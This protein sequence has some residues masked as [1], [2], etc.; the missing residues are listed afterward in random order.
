MRLSACLFALV[1]PFTA[2]PAMADD[3]VVTSVLDTVVLPGVAE[4]AS[5]T[6]QL[7]AAAQADCRATAPAL[8]AAWNGAMDAWLGVQD[9]RFGPLEDAGRRQAIAYWP[10][11]NGHRPR[12]LGRILTAADPILKTP[13]R[14]AAEPV[15]ARGLYAIEAMLYDPAFSGYGPDDPGCGLVRAA[16]ADLAAV[17]AAVDRDWRES[18]AQVMRT[19]GAEGNARFLDPSE[20]RQ[21]IFTALLTSMQ[22]DVLER[23]GRPLG[24]FDRPRPKRAEG[25]FSHRA[26]R[27][28][29][30][31]IAGHRKLAL[32]L[33]PAGADTQVMAEDFDRTEWMAKGLGDPAFAGVSDPGKRFHIEAL[34]GA[35][36]MLRQETSAALG[37]ALGVTVGLNAMDGD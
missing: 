28:L 17:A 34:Q 8:R 33:A 26:Q 15:S 6:A 32:A 4:F 3:P 30:L 9:I 35:L 7:D 12:A 29:A 16:S 5:A 2:G 11:P 1:L 19:A 36:A 23:L 21:A 18:F 37:P 24:S 22:F 31:S 27:N 13:G 14:Y 20:A 25:R 10:D